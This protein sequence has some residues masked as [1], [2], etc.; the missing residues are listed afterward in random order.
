MNQRP[1]DKTP[2]WIVVLGVL[3][4]VAVL[5]LAA[6]WFLLSGGPGDMR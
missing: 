2:L 5:A 1:T 4:G 6:A 3:M